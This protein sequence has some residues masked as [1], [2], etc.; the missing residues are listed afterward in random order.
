MRSAD[1]LDACFAL[2][3]ACPNTDRGRA[4]AAAA[5]PQAARNERRRLLAFMMTPRADARVPRYLIS[6]MKT[7]PPA[8]GTGPACTVP[9][10][11][12]VTFGVVAGVAA[13]KTSSTASRTWRCVGGAAPGGIAQPNALR[14]SHDGGPTT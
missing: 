13:L 1:G 4:A 2:S 11:T 7:R 5:T 10:G 9:A 12:K 8:S 6:K 3:T 14:L